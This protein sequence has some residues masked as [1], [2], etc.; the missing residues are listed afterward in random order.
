MDAAVKGGVILYHEIKKLC[1][2]G[3]PRTVQEL[4]AAVKQAFGISVDIS[5]QHKDPDF[6]D[7]ITLSS[8]DDLQDKDTLKLVYAQSAVILP[9][10]DFNE[11]STAAGCF[12]RSV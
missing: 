10:V 8:T 2:P 9:N 5:L 11:L 4:E 6:N 3:I 1:L 12:S 7:F